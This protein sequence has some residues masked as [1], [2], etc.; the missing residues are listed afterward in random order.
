MATHSSILVWEIPWT[1]EIGG[2]HTVH[3]VMKEMDSTQQLNN[4]NSTELTI[5]F[6][7]LIYFLLAYN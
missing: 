2:L 7:F 6:I 3:G 1:E 5:L 4:N